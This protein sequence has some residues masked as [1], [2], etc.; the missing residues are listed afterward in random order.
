[1]TWGTS[2]IELKK[3]RNKEI[4]EPLT[5]LKD[6]KKDKFQRNDLGSFWFQVEVEKD[7]NI[8]K[9]PGIEQKN[10]RG[11]SPSV[12]RLSVRL[13]DSYL[14][15]LTSFFNV[16]GLFGSIPYQSYNYIGADCA[17][18]LMTAYNIW[19]NKN[20]KK[21]YNVQ[22]LVNTF[23]KAA[24]VVIKNGVPQKAIH[25][26][27]TIKPGYLIAVKYENKKRY[28]HI[29]ALFKDRDN[30]GILSAEDL[31]LHAGP[32]P[33]HLTRLK[34]GGFNGEVIILKTD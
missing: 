21:D 31:I 19:K 27:K 30:D 25:W 13:N 10:E 6:Q 17:D 1:M 20:D 9:T 32:W 12:F 7:E 3:M 24:S 16:P 8:Y 23:E 33:L 14:G 26:G 11:L 28:Q 2:Q 34:R 18:V 22:M 5:F 29:G 15:H 4:I